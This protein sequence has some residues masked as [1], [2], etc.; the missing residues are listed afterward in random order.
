MNNFALKFI[1]LWGWRRLFVAALAG[2][3]AALAAPPIYLIFALF[4]SLPV[5]VWILDGVNAQSSSMWNRAPA[6]FM[7]GWAF[8]FGYFAPNLYW[9]AEAF[10]VDADVFSWMIP[11]VVILF[12][13]GLGIFHGFA[14]LFASL[15]WTSGLAR[16][17]LLASGF[18]A[19]EW[20]RGHIFT[21]FPWATVG[22]SAGAFEGLE[23]LAAYGGV[24]GLT[25]LVVFA[26]ACPAV[27]AGDDD[28]AERG[29]SGRVFGMMAIVLAT[30]VAWIAGSARLSGSQPAFVEDVKVRVI[31]PN[32]AQN[33]KW[34]PK[35]RTEIFDSLLELS[36]MATT[37]EVTGV[38]DVTH[39][40]WP[41]SALPFLLEAN[42]RAREQIAELLPENVTL[43][44]GALRRAPVG[45]PGEPDDNR[46]RNSVLVINHEGKT[47]ASYDKAHLVPFGEYLPFASW[48]E[49]L[50]LRQ[51]VTLPG[52]FVPGFGPRTISLQNAPPVSLLVCY[53]II[54]P[55]AVI[56]RDKRPG[57]ILNVTNDAW[58]G[59]S[60]G[61]RQHFAQSRM[62]A[63]EEG[64]PV[65][66]VANTG[67]SA[68]I[69]PYGRTLK[70]LPLGRRGVVDSALPKAI[71]PT[72]YATF[73]DKI[74][75]MLVLF[76][77][78]LAL[79]LTILTRGPLARNR[80]IS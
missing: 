31:Q 9:V 57:W 48:L 3:V 35:Y 43:I 54:F 42:P 19:L 41:E 18:T 5:L 79:V 20:V 69:D 78:G 15:F 13:L 24:Y 64:L 70:S 26:G 55:R 56:D 21:G 40:V 38:K 58:F 68:V 74:V 32:I 14:V 37:P 17:A 6:A 29:V 62:R 71:P 22:Y 1:L 46:A 66:R 77:L 47:V 8:G 61:P 30:A 60:I 75:L 25:F 27:L 39:V 73:G 44:T 33:R 50:G 23:Q 4:F 10:L 59:E 12:P 63:I 28:E 45:R 49:P 11:F 80:S 76:G 2:I 34:D 51:M 65:V 16:V 67:I 36:D 7:T 53:E 52:S 72:F